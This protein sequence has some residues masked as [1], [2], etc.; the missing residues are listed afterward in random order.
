ML[1]RAVELFADFGLAAAEL[2]HVVARGARLPGR[3]IFCHSLAIATMIAP[4]VDR[5]PA[6]RDVAQEQAGGQ[7]EQRRPEGG[8]RRAG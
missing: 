6:H 2:V 7:P 3:V 8:E 4:E 5:D 1:L